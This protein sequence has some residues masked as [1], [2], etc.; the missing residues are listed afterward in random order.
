MTAFSQR[1]ADLTGVAEDRLERLAGGDL[2]E[3]LL[4]PRAQGALVAKS[5]PS[6]G[7]EA[8]M[9]RTLAGMGI[10]VPTVEG[11]HD[12][13]LLLDYV[14]NDGVL[15][16][17]AWADIG[18]ELARLH[19]RT[20]D[21]YGWPVDYALGTVAL[22]NREGRDWPRFWGEQRLAATAR[23]LDRPWRERVERL[24]GRL[25]DMLPA[26][27]AACLLH[28]DLWTGNILVSG[29]R[30]AALVDPACYYGHAEVDL[31]ML[32]LFGA[33]PG[34]FWEAYGDRERGWEDRLPLYQLFPALVHLRLFGS[35]YAAM[36]ERL[37]DTVGA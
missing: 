3:A 6:V 29:G 23:L 36:V 7:T 26:G 1:V 2:S 16:P 25:G 9:L 22:D 15:S 4:V 21:A 32:C 28:G 35:G 12:G 11:E 24:A 10:K 14:A 17:N 33:P 5:G 20:G 27:P 19:A 34:E 8:A 18:A 37:L 30:L 13:V 31:A